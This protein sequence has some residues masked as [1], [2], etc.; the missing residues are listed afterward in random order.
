[1]KRKIGVTLLLLGAVAVLAFPYEGTIVFQGGHGAKALGMGGAF[2]AIADDATGALWNPAGLAFAGPWIGGATSNRFAAG[3]FPGFGYQYVSGGFV[4]EGYAIG[5]GWANASTPDGIYSASLYLGTVGMQIAD[6]GSLGVNVKYYSE[7]IEGE[8]ASGF[9]FDIGVLFPIGEEFAIG[10]VAKDV[11]GTSMGE[12]Q[13][14]EPQYV[15]GAAL[16]LLEGD[17]TMAA[18]VV[19][20]GIEFTPAELAA[21]LQFVLIPELAIR[22]GIVVP[23][24]DFESYYFTVGAGL[25]IGDFSLDAAYVLQEAP[26]E[27]LVLSATFLL[28]ELLAPAE[29]EPVE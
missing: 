24:L 6:F 25:S 17:L 26:G 9:G 14:V 20:A 13:I 15:A 1:M 3:D 16:K 19:L 23:E 11:G 2:C 10:I 21:G 29:E 22:A 7:S 28:G 5:I 8:A 12:G 27:S 18:D 4:F